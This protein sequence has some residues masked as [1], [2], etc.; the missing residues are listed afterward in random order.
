M[1]IDAMTTLSFIDQWFRKQAAKA[2][3][4]KVR[5]LNRQLAYLTGMPLDLKSAGIDDK[6]ARLEQVATTAMQDGSMLYN[7]REPDRESVIRIVRKLYQTRVK[8][9]PVSEKDLR[10][11]GTGLEKRD[12]KNVFKN[13]EMLYDILMD[14]YERLKTDPGIGPALQKAGLCVQFVYRNPEAV[15][16]IDATKEPPLIIKGAFDGKPDVTMTMNADFAHLFWHGKAN[17]VSALTRRQVTARGNLPK[18][19]KLLPILD[20][21]YEMYPRY[22][23]EKGLGHLVLG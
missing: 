10:P 5:M 18:T 20:P 8:P 11:L 4:E 9:L 19:L 7:P 12:L 14:F 23:R 13:S 21:A 15:I 2:G 22:L 6:L 3:I 17:L 16:T 1:A